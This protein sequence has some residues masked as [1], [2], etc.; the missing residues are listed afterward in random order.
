MNKTINC[1]VCGKPITEKDPFPY[2]EGTYR[3]RKGCGPGSKLWVEK[4]GLSEIGATLQGKTKEAPVR[5][6]DDPLRRAI[7]EFCGREKYLRYMDSVNKHIDCDWQI[8]AVIG[9]K[10]ITQSRSGQGVI[11]PELLYQ[12]LTKG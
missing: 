12:Q 1:G 9:G 10:K 3:H 8:S 7:K 6:K 2:L 4:H 5:Q 11:D